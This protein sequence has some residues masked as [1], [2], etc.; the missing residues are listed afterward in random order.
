MLKVSSQCQG[1][2]VKKVLYDVWP[3]E[4]APMKTRRRIYSPLPLTIL[5]GRFFPFHYSMTPPVVPVPSAFRFF[6]EKDISE[7]PASLREASVAWEPSSD[8]DWSDLA[9]CSV[10]LRTTVPP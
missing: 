10:R 2:F 4:V 6:R 3:E 7:E 8:D 9:A 5:A 1:V